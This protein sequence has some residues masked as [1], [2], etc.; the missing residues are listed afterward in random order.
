MK[1][2]IRSEYKSNMNEL[3]EIIL[4]TSQTITEVKIAGF[5]KDSYKCLLKA[6]N[7]EYQ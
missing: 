4:K 7:D 2:Y 3:I 6:L 1:H 5:I